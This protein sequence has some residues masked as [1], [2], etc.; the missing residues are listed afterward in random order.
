MDPPPLVQDTAAVPVKPAKPVTEI[1]AA[2]VV[3]AP[4]KSMV[5]EVAVCLTLLDNDIAPVLYTAGTAT[6]VK[7]SMAALPAPVVIV[8]V[9]AAATLL[10]IE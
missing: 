4:V 6:P 8:E 9:V 3:D 5:M 7:V 2:A 10:G 1:K